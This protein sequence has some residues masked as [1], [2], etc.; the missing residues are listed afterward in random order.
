VRAYETDA[1][2]EQIKTIADLIEAGNF[3]KA[4]P[5]ASSCL[6]VGSIHGATSI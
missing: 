3:D 4:R 1:Q 5:S 2:H 6:L